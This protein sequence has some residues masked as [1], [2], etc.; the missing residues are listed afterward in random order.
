[1]NLEVQ[2]THSTSKVEVA[3]MNHVKSKRHVRRYETNDISFCI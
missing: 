3:G 1:M 2:V